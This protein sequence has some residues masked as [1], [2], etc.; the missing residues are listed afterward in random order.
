MGKDRGQSRYDRVPSCNSLGI[1]KNYKKKLIA[2]A[3]DEFQQL[4]KKNLLVTGCYIKQ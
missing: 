3:A 2:N 1:L 4:R